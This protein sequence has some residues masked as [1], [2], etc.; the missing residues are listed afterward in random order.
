MVSTSQSL[1]TPFKTHRQVICS[2]SPRGYSSFLSWHLLRVSSCPHQPRG[3]PL[4]SAGAVPR[5][6]GPTAPTTS[7]GTGRGA[8]PR[9]LP[10]PCPFPPR[11]QAAPQTS[12]LVGYGHGATADP[13]ELFPPPQPQFSLERCPTPPAPRTTAVGAQDLARPRQCWQPWSP[14]WPCPATHEGTAAETSWG[15]PREHQPCPVNLTPGIARGGAEQK[16]TEN[17]ERNSG[18]FPFVQVR[19]EQKGDASAPHAAE[20]QPPLTPTT[21]L[22]QPIGASGALPWH[23]VVRGARPDGRPAAPGLPALTSPPSAGVTTRRV[24]LLFY[25]FCFSVCFAF[26]SPQHT[27]LP[28]NSAAKPFAFP[29]TAAAVISSWNSLVRMLHRKEG[30]APRRTPGGCLA[31]AN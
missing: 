17:A 11:H 24:L 2:L 5:S 27:A 25:Q 28:R 29:K 12:L 1:S 31:G 19:R 14:R 23:P 13:E 22:Q 4:P 8:Q 21:R 20:I 6:A 18:P 10:A 26:P 3:L 30:T 9:G 16:R 7:P 15:C